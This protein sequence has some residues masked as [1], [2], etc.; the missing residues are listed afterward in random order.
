MKLSRNRSLLIERTN[1]RAVLL[2][3]VTLLCGVILLFIS[4][5]KRLWGGLEA[6]QA[7]IRDSGS[8]LVASVAVVI[9]WELVGKRAFLDELLGKVQIAEEV[10][11][12]GIIGYGD[13]RHMEWI[14]LFQSVSNLDI[15]FVYGRTWRNTY[16]GQ[17]LSLAERKGARIRVVLPDPE[18]ATTVAELARRFECTTT[19]LSNRIL[20]SANFFL[21]IHDKSKAKGANVE[22]WFLP[23][24]P[25]YSFYTF[26]RIAILA[27]YTHIHERTAVPTFVVEEGGQ[28]YGYIQKEFDSMV[29]EN[30]G[31]ARPARRAT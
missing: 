10:R 28:V 12:A 23:A 31:L 24:A 5:S 16:A 1:L 3:I 25:Q 18:D 14:S 13:F 11:R 9:L 27:M 2:S 4:N 26:D 15:F 8:L 6:I 7:V 29:R 30:K 20:E 19:E 17:L 22:V 21:D